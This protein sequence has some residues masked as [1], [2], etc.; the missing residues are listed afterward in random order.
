MGPG[1]C[2]RGSKTVGYT[3]SFQNAKLV[4]SKKKCTIRKQVPIAKQTD[5]MTA[6]KTRNCDFIGAI[7]EN[8]LQV[9][10][11]K[12]R[13]QNSPDFSSGFRGGQVVDVEYTWCKM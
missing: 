12:S 6:V 3:H 4:K 7:M 8:E 11:V 1:M 10:S 2:R 9:S 5:A 13:S